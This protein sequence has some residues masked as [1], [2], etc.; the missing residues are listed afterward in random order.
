M[1]ESPPPS[2]LQPAQPAGPGGRP[3]RSHKPRVLVL[4]AAGINCDRETSFAFEQA[5]ARTDS[6]HINELLHGR[7]L[8][9]EFGLVVVPGGF[10]YGDDVHAGRVLGIEI[11]AALGDRFGAFLR[12]GG[13]IL[14]I[15]NGFQVLVKSGLLP[16]SDDAG[17]PLPA[18]LGWNDSRRYEDRWVHL[19]VDARR[20]VLAP[21]GRPVLT[22]PVAHGEGRFTVPGEPVLRT[23]E[24]EHRIVFKYVNADLTE[25]VYPANPNGSMGHVAGICDSTGQILGLMPHPERALF[26][27]NHPDWTRTGR[28]EGDGAELF[29]AAVAAMR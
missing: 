28:S 13:L 26:P 8:L 10:S 27:W 1:P 11:A 23:L 6:V 21:A 17:R 29:R 24:S 25:P 15:C 16:G 7:R 12:R 3:A 19:A 20:C 22:L 14:G 18:T 9:D 2:D 5:G 4:R